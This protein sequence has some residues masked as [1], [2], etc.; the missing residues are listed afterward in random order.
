[1]RTSLAGVLLI[2]NGCGPGLVLNWSQKMT[3]E[4]QLSRASLVFVGVIQ[5]ASF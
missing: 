2:L 3:P 4:E 1:V 5:A